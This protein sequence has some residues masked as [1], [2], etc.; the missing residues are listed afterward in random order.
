MAN[1]RYPPLHNTAIVHGDVKSIMSL[2]WCMIKK[3]QLGENL[4]PKHHAQP[5]LSYL[6]RDTAHY[7]YTERERER[8]RCWVTM[9]T[10]DKVFH[11]SQMSLSLR[12]RLQKL[13]K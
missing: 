6:K 11:R 7:T 1:N 8:E 13:M 12:W 5:V 3:F 4:K 10:A 2:F 9:N